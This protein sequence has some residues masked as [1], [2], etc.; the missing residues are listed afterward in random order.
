MKR[1]GF[2]A[3]AVGA[4]SLS[5][6]PLYAQSAD[7]TLTDV[8][9]LFQSRDLGARRMVQDSLRHEGYYSGAIDGAWGP[10]TNAAFRA[11][12]A[13]ARYQRHASTWTF[14][15]EVQVIETMFFLTSD[16]YM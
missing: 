4:A 10:G 14:A 16:A 12:M 6:R 1:R 11:L 13:S 7:V 9:N 2:F 15:Y 8:R 3:A 5:V